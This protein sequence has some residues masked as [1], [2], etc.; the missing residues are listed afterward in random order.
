MNPKK[1]VPLRHTC[2][3]KRAQIGKVLDF[4]PAKH[5]L[6]EVPKFGGQRAKVGVVIRTYWGHK[7]NLKKLIV[8][9][10]LA[11]ECALVDIF[12]V[13]VSTELDKKSKN[14]L[15]ALEKDLKRDARFARNKQVTVQIFEW[16]D[17][18]VAEI[19]TASAAVAPSCTEED[20]SVEG[21]GHRVLCY[22]EGNPMSTWTCDQCMHFWNRIWKRGKKKMASKVCD[23]HNMVDY[24]TTDASLKYVQD[25]CPDC[26]HLLVT[27]GDN[28]YSSVR[29]CVRVYMRTCV[30]ENVRVRESEGACAGESEGGQG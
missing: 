1:K 5:G 25:N 4:R 15:R 14:L 19:W 24:V 23:G 10:A 6:P 29:V 8:D 30:C 28:V 3:L 9:L 20:K 16:T 22:Y 13:V 27:N 2:P 17:A 26:T 12:M 7:N 21:F 18:R 11:A